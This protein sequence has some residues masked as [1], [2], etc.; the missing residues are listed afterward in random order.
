MLRITGYATD[1]AT[2]T[3]KPTI[4]KNTL[5]IDLNTLDPNTTHVFVFNASMGTL[6]K[7]EQ[8]TKPVVDVKTPKESMVLTES[9]E[10]TEHEQQFSVSEGLYTEI[11]HEESLEQFSSSNVFSSNVFSSDSVRTSHSH[12]SCS[13]E[14]DEWEC[15][16][17]TKLK[18][19]EECIYCRQC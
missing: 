11:H 6:T 2:D 19:N 8:N 4:G 15:D 10:K 12:S 13:S 18:N 5:R 14:E 16:C 9:V 3:L 1:T 7:T 17:G